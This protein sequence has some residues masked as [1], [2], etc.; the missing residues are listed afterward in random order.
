MNYRRIV[1]P[2]VPN[3]IRRLNTRPLNMRRVNV[4]YGQPGQRLPTPMPVQNTQFA[5]VPSLPLP[6]PPPRLLPAPTLVETNTSNSTGSTLTYWLSWIVIIIIVIFLIRELY[7]WF[8]QPPDP[9]IVRPEVLGVA[10]NIEGKKKDKNTLH[11]A[12]RFRFPLVWDEDHGEYLVAFRIGHDIVYAV[13]DTGSSY[14]IISAENCRTCAHKHGFYKGETTGVG[15]GEKRVISYGSQTSKV[16]WFIDDFW[17]ENQKQSIKMQFGMVHEIEGDSNLNVL[18]LAGPNTPLSP[19]EFVDQ[20][21]FD[22]KALQ[23]AFWFDFKTNKP[24]LYLG[25]NYSLGE[26]GSVISYYTAAEVTQKTG[27]QL[28]SLNFYLIETSEIIIDGKS[29]DNFP[30]YCMIDTGSTMIILPEHV[31]ANLSGGKILKFK[32]DTLELEYDIE[33]DFLKNAVQ[34]ASWLEK[35][36]FNGEIWILGNRFM[37]G[38]IIE[39]D[40]QKKTIQLI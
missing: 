6:P 35:E 27:L 19:Y 28:E 13:P 2:R 4:P 12:T 38:K 24:A 16:L 40:L 21:F 20:V 9:H 5:Y 26:K 17:V 7:T 18:G 22:A 31:H 14:L 8:L 1:L 25:E 23:P 29:V 15:T 33:H 3:N 11:I 36:P 10:E 30:K 32:F 39:F 34:K 37:V